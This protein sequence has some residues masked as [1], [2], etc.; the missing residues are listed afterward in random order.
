[1]RSLWLLVMTLVC[2]VAVAFAAQQTRN[3][4]SRPDWSSAFAEV[5]VAGTALIFDESRNTWSVFDRPRAERAYTPASTFK[6]F[7]ALTA[8]ETAVLKDEFEVIRWDGKQQS[9]AS[10]N[11]DHSLA[12]GMKF[13]VV[14]F[15]QEIAR[16]IGAE[17]MQGW[18]NKV[19]YG[20]RNIG[21]GIDRFWLDGGALRISA[22]QQ[23]EFLRRLA[24]GSLP[25]SS[26]VQE[27]V[28]RI[29]I[30][31]DAPT[32]T[33]HAKTGWAQKASLDGKNDLGWY[34]GWVE[35][36][37]KRWFF[38]INIDMQAETDA[39]KRLTIARRLLGEIGAF[40]EVP[41][42]AP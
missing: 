5:G 35:R 13:S 4:Q 27:T 33:L 24:D 11:R 40:G 14:W 3:W 16:R 26:S 36:A 17:R 37:G 28:R 31:E 20:N 12:S 18:I 39:P 22:V 23:I 29:T 41:N 21:G 19:D 38:A 1:M 25:F 8:L 15:Y 7:N 34:V 42:R 9:V 30:T 10:W 6:I 2:G 32:Y